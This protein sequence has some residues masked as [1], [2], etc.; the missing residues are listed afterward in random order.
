MA[1]RWQGD[2]GSALNAG[3]VSFNFQGIL[4]SIAKKPYNCDFS[5]VGEGE[6]GSCVLLDT[7]IGCG[8]GS[9]NGSTRLVLC[10]KY[11]C[12]IG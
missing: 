7:R 1:F 10:D 11:Q 3:L 6:S 8:L 4:T 12:L 5:G 2:D 9:G